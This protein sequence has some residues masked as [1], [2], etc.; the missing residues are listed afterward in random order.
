MPLS[1][2]VVL[3]GFALASLLAAAAGDGASPCESVLEELCGKAQKQGKTACD[4]CL[5]ARWSQI[6][7]AQCS[8]KEAEAFC[9]GGGPSPPPGPG[10]TY[11]CWQDK[12]YAGKGTMSKATCDATCGSPPPPGGGYICYDGTCYQKSTGTMTKA[13][14]ESKC[15][16][17]PPGPPPGGDSWQ[18]Y[19]VA[20]MQVQSVVG[21]SN[22]SEYTKVVIMLNTPHQIK[23]RQGAVTVGVWAPFGL[24]RAI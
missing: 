11:E 4:D 18:T 2:A 21:G 10:G 1:T 6:E 20:G 13:Q 24:C 19:T 12:C 3:R 16:G 9:E 7:K 15:S 23:T 5:K 8:L 22:S 14:C 17:P